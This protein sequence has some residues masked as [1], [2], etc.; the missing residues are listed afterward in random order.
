MPASLMTAMRRYF[1]DAQEAQ[2][3]PRQWILQEVR[4]SPGLSQAELAA[5]L[6]LSAAAC[7][8]LL[9]DLNCRGWLT[10]RRCGDAHDTM[11]LTD[12]GK[13]LL[14]GAKSRAFFEA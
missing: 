14:G 7:A 5:R 1:E 2:A 13:A 4:R 9:D 8:A 12:D 10:D 11:E 6:G 3:N